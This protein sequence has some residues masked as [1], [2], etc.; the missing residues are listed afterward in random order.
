MSKTDEGK[1]SEKMRIIKTEEQKKR[2]QLITNTKIY[3][4]TK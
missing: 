2:K 3:I 4:Q 1:K